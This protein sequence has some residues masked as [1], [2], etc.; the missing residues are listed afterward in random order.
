M[1]NLVLLFTDGRNEGDPNSITPAQLGTKLGEANDP[2][3]P[4]RVNVVSFGQDADAALLKH[5]VKPV[6]GYVATIHKAE[7]VAAVFI[8]VAAGGLHG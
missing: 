4:V 8:H 5:A 1:P 6:G 3:R 2:D 7:E